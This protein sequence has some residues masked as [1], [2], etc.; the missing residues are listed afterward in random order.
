MNSLFKWFAD[1]FQKDAVHYTYVYLDPSRSEGRTFQTTPVVSGEHYFSIT[2]A[3]MF[4]SKSKEWFTNR[5]PALYSLIKL[6]FGDKE[7]TFTQVAGPSGLQD[8]DAKSL[9]RGVLLNYSLTPLIPFNGG[10]IELEAGLVSLPGSNEASSLLKVLTDFSKTLAVPQLSVA[11]GFAQPLVDGITTLVGA[12]ETQLTLR[13]HDKFGA[14]KPLSPG[15]LAV[16]SAPEGTFNEPLWV[17]NDK[18]HRGPDQKTA[19]PVVGLDYFLLR[20][21]AVAERDDY[22]AL[23][24]IDGPYQSA[25]AALGEAVVEFEPAKQKDKLL[26]AERL[27]VA[28]KVAAYKAKELTFKTGRRQVIE[29]LQRSFQEAKGLLAPG[30]AEQSSVSKTLAQVMQNAMQADEARLLGEVGPRDLM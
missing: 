2:L 21:D 5:S 3:E 16:L 27:L 18:L 1:R 25:V 23:A 30:A 17:K 10:D 6:K 29:A 24:A 28:A 20:L 14:G 19:Q 15:Y 12:K 8:L 7:E 22:H 13:L 4:L 26:E 9:D 11:L